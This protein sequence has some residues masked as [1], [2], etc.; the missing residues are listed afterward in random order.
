M[1]RAAEQRVAAEPLLG[2]V[3]AAEVGV[4][5]TLEAAAS[6]MRRAVLVALVFVLAGCTGRPRS[7]TWMREHLVRHRAEFDRLV[8][9]SNEDY[10]ASAVIRISSDFTRLKGNWA[11][12][13]P[14]RN[15]GI[16]KT[17]WDEYRALFRALQL[18]SG[19]ERVGEGYQQVQ[20]MVH[21]VGVASEGREYG[22]LWTPTPP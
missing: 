4:G 1:R 3:R 12:P 14:E 15:W 6:A 22:Y 20:L 18:P 17:R 16:P 21:G 2:R 11:W 7:D 5:Q 19:L 13:R 9:M 10:G 8:Q